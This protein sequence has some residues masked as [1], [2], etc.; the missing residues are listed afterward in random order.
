MDIPEFYFDSFEI[1]SGPHGAI[2]NFN[3]GPIEPR[4]QPRGAVARGFSSIENIKSMAFM[5]VRHVKNIEKENGILYPIP[6]KIL[7]QWG[8]S[9]EDWEH[10]WK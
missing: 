8:V 3:L 10:F 5:L 2:I 4:A 6:N 7:N 1:N 9:P